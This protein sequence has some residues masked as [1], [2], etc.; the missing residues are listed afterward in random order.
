MRPVLPRT[1]AVLAIALCAACDRTPPDDE[2]RS[3]DTIVADRSAHAVMNNTNLAGIA[4]LL[5]SAD[6]SLVGTTVDEARALAV[7][8][9]RI[10]LDAIKFLNCDPLI[11]DDPVAGSVDATFDDCHIGALTVDGDSHA[12]VEIE[13]EPCGAEQCATAVVWTLHDF[14]VLV[15]ASASRP[16]F[17]GDVLL[18]DAIQPEGEIDEPMTWTTLPG[19][20]ITNA[21]GVFETS[22]HASWTVDDKRCVDMEMESVLERVDVDEQDPERLI[23]TIVVGVDGLHRC[24]LRCP[25]DGRV[26]LSFGAGALLEW[27]Y[28]DHGE[29]EVMAP[30]GRTFVQQLACAD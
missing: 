10:R 30:H 25:T 19:F 11:M 3:V 24:P 17:T 23:Q 21:L 13:G 18:R 20:T 5:F 4:E 29:V 15:G 16:H 7:A 12:T 14:D 27:T 28:R 22:S 2:Y 9:L 8:S 1:T 26:R 6:P